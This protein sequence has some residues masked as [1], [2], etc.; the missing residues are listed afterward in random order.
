MSDCVCGEINARH[1]PIHGQAATESPRA[2]IYLTLIVED[3]ET[4]NA[5]MAVFLD[6]FTR[7][8]RI[9][10]FDGSIEEAE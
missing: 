4:A 10:E 2:C 3:D 1:C 7:D 8:D 5:M 6:M 9:H